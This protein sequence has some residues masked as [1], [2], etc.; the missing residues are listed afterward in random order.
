[1]TTAGS[2]LEVQTS[3]DGA[4]GWV[5][6]FQS[7]TYGLD[8]AV[9]SPISLGSSTFVRARFLVTA[10]SVDDAGPWS[11]VEEI[12]LTNDPVPSAPTSEDGAWSA[13]NAVDMTFDAPGSSLE[14]WARYV[15]SSGLPEV[16]VEP[17]DAA[18]GLSITNIRDPGTS[19]SPFLLA[20]AVPT[21]DVELIH[22]DVAGGKRKVSTAASVN[23]TMLG[24][25][26]SNLML[27]QPVAGV[28]EIEVS[29]DNGAY[30]TQTVV[31]NCE[32]GVGPLL[33]YLG[34][35]VT[36]AGPDDTQTGP[37]PGLPALSGIGTTVLVRVAHYN[38]SGPG[39]YSIPVEDTIALS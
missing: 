23:V 1:R 14:T 16:T 32:D 33:H 35:P 4:T 36:K 38:T 12:V 8:Q 26:P 9:S 6:Q 5:T 37:Q 7:A 11:A 21:E 29:W 39:R 15:G 27:S 19:Y 30:G 20:A 25:G 22:V 24:E 17:S 34:P 28:P 31:L 2:K 13:P 10:F 18:T 3:P